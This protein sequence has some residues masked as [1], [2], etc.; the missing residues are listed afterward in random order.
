MYTLYIHNCMH[1]LYT[2][3]HT[4]CTYTYTHTQ[5]QDLIMI[6]CNIGNVLYHHLYICFHTISHAMKDT[7]TSASARA[8]IEILGVHSGGV[9]T[10]LWNPFAEEALKEAVTATASAAPVNAATATTAAT[11]TATALSVGFDEYI[12]LTAG[13]EEILDI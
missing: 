2:F 3:T 4:V 1:V 7:R 10:V 5:I 6:I 9:H 8:D 12:F 13:D 11:S